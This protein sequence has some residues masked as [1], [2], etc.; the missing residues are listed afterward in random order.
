M[1]SDL[2]D[3]NIVK[4]LT[5]FSISPGSKYNRKEIKEKTKMNNLPLD[6]AL[7]RL[8]KSEI[9]KQEK[10]LYF[11]NLN[12]PSEVKDLWKYIYHVY[13]DKFHSLPFDIFYILIEISDKLSLIKSI[14]NIFLFGSYAKLIYKED[15]DVDIAIIFY[16][17]IKDKMR[18]EKKINKII[19]KIEKKNKKRIEIHFF[20]EEDLKHKEDPLIKDI[21]KNNIQII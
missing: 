13:Y 17:K 16:K 21:I 10:N 18:E 14:K 1:I 11:L 3:K 4:I 20:S 2:F 19:A 5:F 12:E 6:N 7:I 8:L 9:L 15:S